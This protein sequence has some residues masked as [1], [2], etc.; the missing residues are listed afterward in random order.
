MI[1]FKCTMCGA[2]CSNLGKDQMVLL[3]RSDVGE[4]SR[5]LGMAEAEIVSSYCEVN[6]DFTARA[7]TT[8]LQL[9]SSDG[10]C[11]FLRRDNRCSVHEHK[12]FQ[13]QNGPDRF[14]QSAMSNDYECMKG[15][16]VARDCDLTEFF[17]LSLLE[18]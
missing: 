3:L 15:V 2:C 6:A 5:A 8:I 17:F 10:R 7:G 9:K 11:V 4:L 12:P 14:L 16:S 13:C 1:E 18:D